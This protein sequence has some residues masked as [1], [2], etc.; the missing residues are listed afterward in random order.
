M[1]SKRIVKML[2]METK[3]EIY[4]FYK[5][6]DFNTKKELA[7]K[8]NISTRTLGRVI[9]E[10]TAT[11]HEISYDY[12]ITKNQITIFKDDVSRSVVKGYPS[13][14]TIKESLVACDFSDE[15]LEEAYVLLDIPY[16]VN[17]FS[18]GNITVDHKTGSVWYNNF[19]IKNSITDRLFDMLNTV[20]DND[21]TNLLPLVRFLD[22]V[23]L[24]PKK[25][26]VDELY[27]FL[28]FNDI[29]ITE[30]GNIIAFKSVRSDWKDHYSNTIDNS[31]GEAVTMPRYLV[32]FNPDEPCSV[33]LHCA[34][35]TYAKV[36]G[37]GRIV[38]VL[39]DP[40]DVVSVPYDYNGS[41]MRVCK[42]KVINEVDCHGKDI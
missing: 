20:Q 32:D 31:V 7:K 24:N 22:K 4:N 36:F 37:N 28:E 23:L 25:C 34:S 33:G 38:K 35:L 29:G 13:F 42:Y 12:S 16:F 15:S 27:P 3:V 17:K 9:D 11:F 1:G 21:Y 2:D 18:E 40:V 8:Y 30:D 26:I 19:E 39:I 14:N 10:M 41:K 5:S 6:E